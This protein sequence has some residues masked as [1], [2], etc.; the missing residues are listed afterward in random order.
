V[1]LPSLLYFYRARLRA[2]WSLELLALV[3]I[4]VG[5]ALLFAAQIAS[6]SLTGSVE[7]L[8]SGTIGRAEFQVAARNASGMPEST[9]AEIRELQG[10]Q[11]AAPLLE[12]RTNVVGPKGR[13]TVTLLGIS[14][15]LIRIAGPVLNQYRDS[16]LPVAEAIA[17]PSPIARS[18][19]ISLG[20]PVELEIGARTE[21]THMAV[22]L[23]RAEIGSLTHSPIAVA[24]LPYTQTLAEAPDRITRV[25]VQP[26]PGH[27]D[28]VEKELERVAGSRFDVRPANAEIALFRQAAGPLNKSTTMFAAISALVGFLFAFSAMLLTLNQRKDLV[29]DLRLD[30]YRPWAVIMVL[31]FDA[32]VLGVIAS[33]VGLALG[34]QLSRL[35]F[36][37]APGYLSYAFSVGDQRIIDARSIAISMAGGIAATLLAALLPL[38]GIFSRPPEAQR[39]ETVGTT[40]HLA[41]RL[42]VAGLV[43]LVLS[44]PVVVAAPGATGVGLVLLTAA[45]MFVL[46]TALLIALRLAA[47]LTENARSVIPT[48]SV[49]ELRTMHARSV[50]LAAIGAL[51][52]FGIVAIQGSRGD[53]QEGL[54]RAVEEVDGVADVWVAPAGAANTLATTSFDPRPTTNALH[55]L[56]G[57]A[58]VRRYRASFLDVGHRRLW[59]LAPPVDVRTPIPPSQFLEEDLPTATERVRAGGWA[60]VSKAF[61]DDHDLDVGERFTLPAPHPITLRVAGLS[62]NIGWPPGAIIL[63]AADYRQAWGSSDPSAYNIMVKP[64]TSPQSVRNTVAHALGPASALKVETTGERQARKRHLGRQALSRL[65]QLAILMLIATVLAMAAATAGM[66]WQRR[67]RLASLKL[68]GV[69]ERTV[70]LALVLES[71][72]LLSVGCLIGSVFGLYGHQ[73]LDRALTNV[74]GFPVAHSLGIETAFASFGIVTVVAVLIASVPGYFAAQAPARLGLQE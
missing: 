57:V 5:V 7:R 30:G 63:N 64:G 42:L 20:G 27:H 24:A 14:P 43:C 18:L 19:G 36:E 17:L 70:W 45:M 72:I 41:H 25:L 52:V 46:P 9:L 56:P 10:V 60:V 53:L 51:A 48:I 8:I 13:T 50:A 74:T 73:L 58:E 1:R 22:T 3:G 15:S 35:V 69:N 71:A 47:R 32:L 31:S 23:G 40:T 61:A 55:R 59:V 54:D 11:D 39:V 34:D 12:V 67:A 28:E 26:V 4:A 2:R 49:G 29:D 16:Q 21:L 38:R 62:T 65:N 68:D 37:N 33:L 44:V 6:T 66:V